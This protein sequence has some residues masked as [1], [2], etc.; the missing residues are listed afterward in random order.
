MFLS[1]FLVISFVGIAL[2]ISKMHCKKYANKNKLVK[3]MIESIIS[4]SYNNMTAFM[5]RYLSKLNYTTFKFINMKNIHKTFSS[6]PPKP[7]AFVSLRLQS[8]HALLEQI[9]MMHDAT[10]EA[11]GF[12]K[13]ALA[14]VE[15]FKTLLIDF[16]VRFEFSQEYHQDHPEG[17]RGNFFYPDEM[18]D[19]V[20]DHVRRLLQHSY[21]RNIENVNIRQQ[22]S[23]RLFDIMHT[24]RDVFNM[25]F[26]MDSPIIRATRDIANVPQIPHNFPPSP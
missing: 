11:K 21:Q 16:N 25:S 20:K 17:Q 8:T 19:F 2:L 12:V 24:S 3:L 4:R 7:H 1:I 13:I 9:A 14:D 23:G 26:A 10:L 18:D 6:F 22:I 5:S 15:R